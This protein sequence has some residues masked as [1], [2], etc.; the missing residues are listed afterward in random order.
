MRMSKVW[1]ARGQLDQRV[2]LVRG[3]RAAEKRLWRLLIPWGIDAG[4]SDRLCF[5][6]PSP[7]TVWFG[8]NERAS[9][10]VI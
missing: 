3:A 10:P 7:D 2:T 4:G 9:T 8:G 1:A 6:V 5:Q